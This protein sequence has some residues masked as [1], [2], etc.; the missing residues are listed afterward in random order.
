MRHKRGKE[1]EEEE[2]KIIRTAVRSIF[3][4]SMH[5]RSVFPFNARASLL[6]LK[7]IIFYFHRNK[8][9]QVLA[10]EIGARSGQCLYDSDLKIHLI[11]SDLNSIQF[12][13]LKKVKL[14]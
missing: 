13:F 8:D 2:G 7:K 11:F 14:I 3:L 5:V 4:V 1:E 10:N 12:I 9:S 6:T